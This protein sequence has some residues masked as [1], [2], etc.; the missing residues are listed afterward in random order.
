MGGIYEDFDIF[1]IIN[2]FNRLFYEYAFALY[3]RV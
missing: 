2:I 3:L 1:S